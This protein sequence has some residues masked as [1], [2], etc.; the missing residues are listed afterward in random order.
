[1][2]E[3]GKKQK[4]PDHAFASDEGMVWRHAGSRAECPPVPVQANQAE[5]FLRPRARRARS[6]LRPP[7]VAMRARKPWRRARTRR[8]GWKVRFMSVLEIQQLG[9]EGREQESR[10][11]RTT[12]EQKRAVTGAPAESQGGPTLTGHSLQRIFH[13]GEGN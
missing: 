11:Y 6:T 3:L 2:P 8:L 13:S 5:S 4:A 9:P 10:P 1:M 7:T 12:A